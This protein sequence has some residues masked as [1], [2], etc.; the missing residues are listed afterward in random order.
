MKK[1]ML[2]LVL[3]GVMGMSTL[4]GCSPILQFMSAK[5]DSTEETYTTENVTE[6]YVVTE[7]PEM[8][9]EVTEEVGTTEETAVTEAPASG[10]VDFDVVEG[11]LENPGKLGEW[12]ATKTYSGEDEKYHT[13]YYRI[14]G[15]IRGDEAKKVVDDYNSGDHFMKFDELEHDD[16]EYC[17]VTYETHY[18]SD[19]PEGEYG[20]YSADVDLNVCNLEDSGAIEGYIGLSSVYDI[21]EEPEEF[22][23]GQTFTEGKAVFAMVKDFKDYL[24]TASYYDDDS[25]EF[26]SYVKAE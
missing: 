19:F 7:E 23:A 9:E 4:T 11:T 25:N 26:C 24:F 18:P 8:T 22:H 21:S 15:V 14:T 17:V 5:K 10:E 1:K 2:A 6:D 20:L 3:V 16:I 12:V 13:I